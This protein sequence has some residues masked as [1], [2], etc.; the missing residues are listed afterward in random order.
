[1]SPS[2]TVHSE[3]ADVDEAEIRGEL[4]LCERKTEIEVAGFSM[5]RRG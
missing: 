2:V 4:R 1:M 3:C 5:L